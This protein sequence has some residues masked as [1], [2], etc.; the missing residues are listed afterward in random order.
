M[1]GF[2]GAET[3]GVTEAEDCGFEMASNCSSRRACYLGLG[4][5]KV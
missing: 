1:T 5:E 4:F 2:S 3:E